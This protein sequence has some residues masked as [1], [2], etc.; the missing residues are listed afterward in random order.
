MRPSIARGNEQ[1]N[2]RFA[3][4]I[5]LPRP[6]SARQVYLVACKPLLIFCPAEGG[7]WMSEWVKI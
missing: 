7:G 4:D 1:L 3:A 2:P 6:Q 5:G